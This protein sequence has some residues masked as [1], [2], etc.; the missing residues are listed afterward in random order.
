MSSCK[1]ETYV[2][3]GHQVCHGGAT[4]SFLLFI[5]TSFVIF[6]ILVILHIIVV[7]VTHLCNEKRCRWVRCKVIVK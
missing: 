2:F 7:F 4:R 5:I 3:A 1:K 6:I